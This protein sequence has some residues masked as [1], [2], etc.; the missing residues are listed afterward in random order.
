MVSTASLQSFVLSIRPESHSSRVRAPSSVF[1]NVIWTRYRNIE[2]RVIYLPRCL[3][4][5]LNVT[6]GHIESLI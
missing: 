2:G 4:R 3:V 1:R 6:D 5:R